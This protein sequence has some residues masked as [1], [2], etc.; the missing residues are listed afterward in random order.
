MIHNIGDYAA[1]VP[2]LPGRVHGVRCELPSDAEGR[3]EQNPGKS[4]GAPRIY[5]GCMMC[6]VREW[7]FS[8]NCIIYIPLSSIFENAD[9][10]YIAR[11]CL[12]RGRAAVRVT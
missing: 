7:G 5:I 9:V 12:R 11:E 4:M 3:E 1:A 8:Q 10:Q 2:A 6:I